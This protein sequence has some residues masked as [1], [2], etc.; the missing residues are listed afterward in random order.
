MLIYNQRHAITVFDQYARHFKG[1][2]PHQSL[3]QPSPN[4]DPATVVPLDAPIRRR[5]VLQGVINEYHGAA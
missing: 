4:D 1:H 3:Q 2:R 5:K